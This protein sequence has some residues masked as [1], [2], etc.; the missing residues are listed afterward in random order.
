MIIGGGVNCLNMKE[1]PGKDEDIS[2]TIDLDFLCQTFKSYKV[3]FRNKATCPF[4]RGNWIIDFFIENEI[5]PVF[6]LKI[7][8]SMTQEHVNKFLKP[9]KDKMGN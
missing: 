8:V 9:L 7:P 6:C 4:N 1:V 5:I 2:T 3:Y